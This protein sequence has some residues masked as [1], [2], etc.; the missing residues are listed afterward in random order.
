M[1][2]SVITGTQQQ[3]HHPVRTGVLLSAVVAG[4]AVVAFALTRENSADT[5]PATLPAIFADE[6]L[7]AYPEHMSQA[8]RFRAVAPNSAAPA[9][10]DEAMRSMAGTN[11]ELS[12]TPALT[13]QAA[14]KAAIEKALATTPAPEVSGVGERDQVAE[15]AVRAAVEASQRQAGEALASMASDEFGTQVLG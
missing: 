9:G 13:D 4:A 12:V 6:S 3:N 1:T 15:D 11:A 14:I 2:A 8:E 5:A 7:S 10:I